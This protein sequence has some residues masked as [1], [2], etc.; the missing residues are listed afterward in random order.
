VYIRVN[1]WLKSISSRLS[2]VC[3]DVSETLE[4]LRYEQHGLSAPPLRKRT[5]RAG[6]VPCVL[7]AA[8][9]RANRF[10]TSYRQDHRR[11]QRRQQPVPLQFL[12]ARAQVP[13]PWAFIQRIAIRKRK[14]TIRGSTL[15]RHSLSY[16]GQPTSSNAEVATRASYRPTTA[17]PIRD[18]KNKSPAHMIASDPERRALLHRLNWGSGA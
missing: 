4:R 5:Q 16:R 15:M 2:F 9:S 14:L 3:V 11:D 18:S 7:Y 8:A 10:C 6:D 1:P 17:S 12:L 13:L